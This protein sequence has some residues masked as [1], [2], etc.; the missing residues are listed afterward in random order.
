MR[1]KKNLPKD[2]SIS[3][4]EVW[5]TERDYLAR[6]DRYKYIRKEKAQVNSC[7]FCSIYSQGINEESLCLYQDDCSLV[8]INKYPYNS[9]H[10]LILPKRH[11]GSISGLTDKELLHISKLLRESSKILES[12]YSCTGLN[13]GCNQ[14]AIAGAGL[15]N[16]LHWHIIPRWAGDTNFFPL[17]AETKLTLEKVQDT[18]AK[19]LPRFKKIKITK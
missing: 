3:L 14:G 8:V 6:P 17:I 19:L 18:Y 9:G 10:L 5:P 15:P 7:V 13:L 12:V 4:T 11:M 2:A 1:M 16:H